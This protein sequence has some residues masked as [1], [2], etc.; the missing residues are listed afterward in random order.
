MILVSDEL[1]AALQTAVSIGTIPEPQRGK[2]GSA[3][4]VLASAV[5]KLLAEVSEMDAKLT[6]LGTIANDLTHQL[7]EARR[8][9]P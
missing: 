9:T 8:K 5:F 6:K 1:K 2:V 3:A 7:E 4:V